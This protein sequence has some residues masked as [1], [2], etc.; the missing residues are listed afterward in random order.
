MAA[1]AKL[2]DEHLQVT[3][4]V[5]R[6]RAAQTSDQPVSTHVHQQQARLHHAFAPGAQTQRRLDPVRIALLVLAPVM[7]WSLLLT[8]GILVVRAIVH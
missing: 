5:R 4:R 3:P 7:L 6:V 8:G 2:R 1:V